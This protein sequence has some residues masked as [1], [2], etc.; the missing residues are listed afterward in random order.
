MPETDCRGDERDLPGIFKAGYDP[1]MSDS[2]KSS[3]AFYAC[4][5]LAGLF[6]V[7]V[8]Y[9]LSFGPAC[10]TGNRIPLLKPCVRTTYMPLARAAWAYP[11]GACLNA[12]WWWG[13]FGETGGGDSL[14]IL[15]SAT[16]RSEYEK[17]WIS[18]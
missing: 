9:P 13:A 2:R 7:L 17:S 16:P 18:Q 8:M 10:W 4:V 1:G 14:L 15:M 12:L 5:V 3:A 6:V 11:G